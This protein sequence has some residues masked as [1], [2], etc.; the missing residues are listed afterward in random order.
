MHNQESA[1]EN[2]FFLTGRSAFRQLYDAIGLELDFY[3]APKLTSL[4][5]TIPRLQNPQQLLLVHNVVTSQEDLNLLSQSPA[6]KHI[7][8]L[9]FCLCPNANQYINRSVPPVELFRKNNCRIVL[10]TDSL[11]SNYQLSIT[12]EMKT[13][14]VS[15]PSIQPEELLQWATSNGAQA[16]G[17]SDR[18]G[19]FEQGKTP[20][21]TLIETTDKHGN[22]VF[23]NSKRLL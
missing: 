7:P 18:F 20:G 13:L 1:D 11:A 3:T 9:Y 8:P 12:E 17:I 19:S 15:H 23:S 4:Q 10:G 5:A 6:G 22:T 14:Q 21:I 16:L 2:D